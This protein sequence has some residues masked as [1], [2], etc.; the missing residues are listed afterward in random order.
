MV[1]YKLNLKDIKSVSEIL[2]VDNKLISPTSN[3]RV[4]D[5][6]RKIS[7][8]CTNRLNFTNGE[9]VDITID[10][11]RKGVINFS[12]NTF[13]L[14]YLNPYKYDSDIKYSIYDLGLFLKYDGGVEYKL[15]TNNMSDYNFKYN[16]ITNGLPYVLIN[17]EVKVVNNL[18]LIQN[19]EIEDLGI[20]YKGTID[21][22][23]YDVDSMIIENNYGLYIKL[24]KDNG[25]VIN[26]DVDDIIDVYSTNTEQFKH[27]VNPGDTT[28]VHLGVS[29]P[30]KN[31]LKTT[32]ILNGDE[33]E[34][35]FIDDVEGYFNEDIK[36]KRIS[37]TEASIVSYTGEDMFENKVVDLKF[38]SGITINNV[39]YYVETE[40]VSP[41]LL[42]GEITSFN[43]ITIND[44]KIGSLCVLSK[45]SPSIMM[46]EV[47][48]QNTIFNEH[49]EVYRNYAK[50]V[51]KFM[52]ENKVIFKIRDDKFNDINETDSK[53][54]AKV[55]N[56]L[57]IEHYNSSITLPLYLNNTYRANMNQEM[58]LNKVYGEQIKNRIRNNPENRIVDMEK[59]I[60]TPVYLIDNVFK[61][62]LSLNFNFHFR[63]RDLDTWKVIEDDKSLGSINKCNWFVTDCYNSSVIDSTLTS[64]GP[65]DEVQNQMNSSDLL[66]F[67]GFNDDDVYNRK[68]KLSKSFVR[69]SFYDS[70]DI[71]TQNLLY[72]STI[73]IDAGKLF[74]KYLKSL[75]KPLSVT[76]LLMN[77]RNEIGVYPSLTPYNGNI[78]VSTERAMRKFIL[79]THKNVIVFNENERL[80]S[81]IST[82]NRNN[83][84]GS[85]S[86]FYLY[87]YKEF[88][89]NLH[90]R[91]IYMKVEFNHA[92]M[93][94][95]VPFMLLRDNKGKIIKK[96]DEITNEIKS[97]YSIVEAHNN[98][99]IPINIIYNEKLKK[100]IYYFEDEELNNKNVNL[101]LFEIKYKSVETIIEK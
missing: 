6:Y 16:S 1:E 100:Y 3:L 39:N 80:S 64:T 11:T 72:Y 36:I 21:G 68:K 27:I 54:M 76:D 79:N 35:T 95:T 20:H 12:G 38:Y 98:M 81:R 70:P 59:D 89:N 9:I 66:F 10:D 51:T 74:E 34:V 85:S 73:N 92:G 87:L 46:C 31:E 82:Y 55:K 93:G 44:N 32:V 13:T 42:G 67:L 88:S 65:S 26:G 30:I 101:N 86:G 19:N 37:D 62:I 61:D 40:Y 43:Y 23:E 69:L 50:E 5:D 41:G 96:I 45:D 22:T 71:A 8:T 47:D 17:G 94:Q 83:P 56:K 52:S 18:T 24:Y 97:G 28:V 2:S 49:N 60:Y 25:D 78:S 91:R 33:F 75:T 14:T 84:L 48:T 58:L 57:T 53:F 63:T 15:Y 77:G 7:G 29:Y 4:F 99:F 90:P